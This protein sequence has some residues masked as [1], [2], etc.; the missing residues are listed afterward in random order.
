MSSLKS[1]IQ[2]LDHCHCHLTSIVVMRTRAVCQYKQEDESHVQTNCS[3]TGELG[4]GGFL[5]VFQ[6]RTFADSGT[7]LTL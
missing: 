3:F 5:H 7:G 4:L 1:I 6:K 2:K